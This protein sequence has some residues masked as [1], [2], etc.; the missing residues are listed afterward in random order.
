MNFILSL[1]LVVQSDAK[2]N[3]KMEF[4]VAIIVVV[5]I[6]VVIYLTREHLKKS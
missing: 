3:D 1:L 4:V 6:L 5:L 2:Y